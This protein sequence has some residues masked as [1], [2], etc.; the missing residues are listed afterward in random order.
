MGKKGVRNSS[1]CGYNWFIFPNSYSCGK[2]K[3]V[4]SNTGR[5]FCFNSNVCASYKCDTNITETYL[6]LL[7]CSFL[8]IATE[9]PFSLYQVKLLPNHL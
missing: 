9:S 2:N 8:K 1:A 3:A 5:F 7:P 6:I 4:L